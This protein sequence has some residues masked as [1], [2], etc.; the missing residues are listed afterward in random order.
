MSAGVHRP[1]A[2]LDAGITGRGRW[3][4]L[5]FV[6]AGLASPADAVDVGA[7]LAW[8]VAS[9]LGTG[10]ALPYATDGKVWRSASAARDARVAAAVRAG[11]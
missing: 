8:A 9:S 5:A 2:P 10:H 6:A 7:G 4:V 1:A 3:G 11:G